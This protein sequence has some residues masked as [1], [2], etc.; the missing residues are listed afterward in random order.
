[1]KYF[2]NLSDFIKRKPQSLALWQTGQLLYIILHSTTTVF[3]YT[4]TSVVTK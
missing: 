1:M 3:A 4:E 2:R